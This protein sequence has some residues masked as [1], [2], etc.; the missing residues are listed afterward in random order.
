M[1]V[2]PFSG[3]VLH[4]HL[5]LLLGYRL[6]TSFHNLKRFDLTLPTFSSSSELDPWGLSESSLTAAEP[7]P[8]VFSCCFNAS[9][10]KCSGVQI[11][12]GALNISIGL[13]SASV[14]PSI[15]TAPIKK[16]WLLK[17]LPIDLKFEGAYSSAATPPE[18]TYQNATAVSLT[19][20][21]ALNGLVA[22]KP[23]VYTYRISG[24]WTD[25]FINSYYQFIMQ[26]YSLKVLPPNTTEDWISLIR[27]QMPSPT[28]IQKDIVFSVTI[29]PDPLVGGA[30][31]T[32]NVTMSQWVFWNFASA[33]ASVINL[34]GLG[35]K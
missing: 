9:T 32:E 20:N 17:L 5:H 23:N 7:E 15:F 19:T 24:A 18:I 28:S 10:A 29:P 26:D 34:V 22:T 6:L 8:L 1:Y 31:T 4:C 16:L 35:E 2:P 25:A 12:E 33:R 30:A 27:Y 14:F 13:F 21:V 11:L 3:A